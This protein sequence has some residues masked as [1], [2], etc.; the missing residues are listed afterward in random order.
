MKVKIEDA[1]GSDVFVPY[2]VTFF[3][4]TPE[5]SSKFHNRIAIKVT[6][7]PHSFIGNIYKRGH[8]EAKGPAEFEI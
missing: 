7:G 3:I 5:E 8:G 1:Q 6:D 2:T 4:H